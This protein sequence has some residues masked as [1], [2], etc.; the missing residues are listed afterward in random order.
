MDQSEIKIFQ[1]DEGLTEVQVKFYHE[2]AWLSQKNMAQLFEKDADTIGLH[3]KNI[4]K[5]G[6][7]VEI[8]TTEFS[9]VVQHEGTLR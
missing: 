2:T 4:Y 3:L 1:S 6:E 9:S 8:S 5:S 7:L